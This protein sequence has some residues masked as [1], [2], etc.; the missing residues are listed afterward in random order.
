LDKRAA[1]QEKIAGF[2]ARASWLM[3]ELWDT[4]RR[5]HYLLR[6]DVPRVASLDEMVWPSVFRG[7]VWA[8]KGDLDWH[9]PERPSWIGPNDPL[10]ESLSKLRETVVR[11]RYPGE[12]SIVAISVFGT[13]E[14]FD[15]GQMQGR[16]DGV[17]PSE[18]D[19]N[20]RFLGFDVIDGYGHI[21]GLSNCGY[22]PEE[23]APLESEWARHLNEWH[24]FSSYEHADRFRIV[25]DERVKEHSPF[26]VNGLY[27]IESI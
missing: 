21:S 26:V 18:P 9:A 24:L 11:C 12:V 16:F 5:D 17:E 8:P 22:F 10:W 6:R 23:R 3:S 27:L 7:S 2:D 19:A 20:W 25:S 1:V 13:P 15:S 14:Y 4:A